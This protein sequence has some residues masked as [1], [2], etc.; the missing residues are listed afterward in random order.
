MEEGGSVRVSR[1]KE[2]ALE[3]PVV[4]QDRKRTRLARHRPGLPPSHN[5]VT[6]VSWS[7]KELRK[8]IHINKK[9]HSDVN[10]ISQ[11]EA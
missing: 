9:T 3:G 6:A 4:V 8:L 7:G 11:A 1:D 10:A 5:N 2:G